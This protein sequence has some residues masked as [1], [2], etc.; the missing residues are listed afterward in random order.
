MAASGKLGWYVV[1]KGEKL[2]RRTKAE[3]MTLA[4]KI[5]DE[6]GRQVRCMP[7]KATRTKAAAPRRL[8][9]RRNPAGRDRPEF[10]AGVAEKV[11]QAGYRMTPA[12]WRH[13]DFIAREGRASQVGAANLIITWLREGFYAGSAYAT[14]ARGRTVRDKRPPAAPKVAKRKLTAKRN[15]MMRGVNYTGEQWRIV[16]VG[17]GNRRMTAH[18]DSRAEAE[19]EADFLDAMGYRALTIRRVDKYVSRLSPSRLPV[20]RRSTR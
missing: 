9:T 7:V 8:S 19:R 13:L 6:T 16:G 5:A 3:I 18:A 11:R 15:P 2:V 17:P 4:R 12:A 1:H 20:G 10:R 14:A